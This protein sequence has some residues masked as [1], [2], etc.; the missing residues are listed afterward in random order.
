MH[1]VVVYILTCNFVDPPASEDSGS[2]VD[3]TNDSGVEDAE[4]VDL[5]SPVS[6]ATLHTVHAHPQCCTM[7]SLFP[8]YVFQDHQRR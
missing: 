3:L 2:V 6:T 4:L 7:C 1:F 8:C 5:T